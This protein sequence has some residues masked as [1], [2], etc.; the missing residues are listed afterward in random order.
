MAPSN[1]LGSERATR[2]SVRETV[3]SLDIAA[4]SI[5]ESQ[6]IAGTVASLIAERSLDHHWEGLYQYAAIRVGPERAAVLLGQLEQEVEGKPRDNLDLPPGPQSFL[7]RR[8]RA[9]VSGS[10]PVHA[11]PDS[12]L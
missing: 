10:Q 12:A 3:R 9:L 8:M 4:R 5:V 2:L 7:Y 1:L 11:A 6:A